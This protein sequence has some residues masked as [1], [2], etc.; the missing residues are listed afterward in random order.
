MPARKWTDEQFIEAVKTS[1]SIAEVLRKLDLRICNSAYPRFHKQA[2]RLGIDYSHFT[3]QGW[4][5]GAS[6]LKKPRKPLAEI[7]TENSKYHTHILRLRLIREG[8]LPNCC[9]KCKLGPEWNGEILVLQLDH[10]NGVNN[11]HRLN[12]LRLL[13]PN[14]HSQTETYCSK[15]TK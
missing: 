12:N 3:G 14:C 13:C 11:D 15:N 7:M 2:K 4:S 5:K 10:I 9:A 1:E 6:G 8:I